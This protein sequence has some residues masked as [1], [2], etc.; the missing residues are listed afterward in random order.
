MAAEQ[1]PDGRAPSEGRAGRAPL[2][3]DVWADVVCPWCYIGVHRIA[4]AVALSMH[5]ADIE[6]RPRSFQL[7]PEAPAGVMNAVEF[8]A[9]A[10]GENVDR[11]RAKGERLARQARAEGLVYE[12]DHVT[13]NS[14][15]M[16]RLVH[17]GL[18][19]GV[20]WR[21]LQS[22]QAAVFGGGPEAFEP[23][24]LLRLGVA[25]G[26]PA[27]RIREVL[28]GDRYADEVRGDRQEAI[29]RG[30]TG[31]PFAVFA[32]DEVVPGAASVER[33]AGVIDRSWSRVCTRG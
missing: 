14:F 33:Y 2:V 13:G 21:Y 30:V 11:V 16:L 18:R 17:L 32:G 24:T 22:M 23:D 15:D 25:I 5:A 27:A 12:T 6:L 3:I 8:L 4:R 7:E 20:G 10:A 28:N 9:H 1:S 19:H 29:D 31:V 26:I